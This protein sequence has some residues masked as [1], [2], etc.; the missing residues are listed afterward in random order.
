MAESK[1]AGRFTV[2]SLRPD[3]GGSSTQEQ[4]G[5]NWSFEQGEIREQ[6][7]RAGYSSRGVER[8][9]YNN[10]YA[11]TCERVW[12]DGKIVFAVELGELD[13]DLNKVKVAQEYQVVYG[14]DLDAE[15]KKRGEP[16]MVTG[17]YN[18]YDSVPGMEKYSPLWQF[19]YVIVPRGYVPNAL[20]SER[21]CLQ[22]GYPIIRS[23]VVEN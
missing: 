3:A 22:S 17:Q 5:P 11:Q 16:E 1:A 8:L 19:N 18:I 12:F 15:G 14:V 6:A 2:G 4:E 21:D 10:P 13:L 20:R 7:G 23:T 9:T